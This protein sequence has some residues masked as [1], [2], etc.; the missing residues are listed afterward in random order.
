MHREHAAPA[1][2]SLLLAKHFRHDHAT[3]Q[4]VAVLAIRRNHGVVRLERLHHADGHAFLA[5]VEVEES[6]DFLLCVK[7]RGFLLEMSDQQHL[8]QQEQRMFAG[9]ARLR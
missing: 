5:D 2:A 4:R 7:L 8:P 6:A 3:R 9:R 1:A